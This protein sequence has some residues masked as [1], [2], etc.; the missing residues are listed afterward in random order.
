[1]SGVI[2]YFQQR[3]GPLPVQKAF[4]HSHPEPRGQAR[5]LQLVEGLSPHPFAGENHE[6]TFFFKRREQ[7]MQ[8]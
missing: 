7:E 4:W 5:D 6:M 8:R 1:V 2:A 3:T